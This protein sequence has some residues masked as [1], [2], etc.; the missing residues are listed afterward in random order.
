MANEPLAFT[1]SNKFSSSA[2][3]CRN[4]GHD[5]FKKKKKFQYMCATACRKN[6]KSIAALATENSTAH[7]MILQEVCNVSDA[8]LNKTDTG[9]YMCV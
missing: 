7:L 1:N 8:R 2:L 5:G 3:H 4:T 9:I 6:N